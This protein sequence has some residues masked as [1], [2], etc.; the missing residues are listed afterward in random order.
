MFPRKL[1]GFGAAIDLSFVRVHSRPLFVYIR[2]SSVSYSLCPFAAIPRPRKLNPAAAGLYS[3]HQLAAPLDSPPTLLVFPPITNHLS[4]PPSPYVS[5]RHH[6]PRCP[7]RYLDRSLRNES[8]EPGQPGLPYVW[9]TYDCGF[10]SALPNRS[11][12]SRVL[13]D[14]VVTVYAGL[15]LPIPWTCGRR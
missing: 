1:L 6:I 9:Y 14:P 13:E 10:N 11:T 4:R 3:F 15:D 12:N 8:S 2:R 5:F 7:R